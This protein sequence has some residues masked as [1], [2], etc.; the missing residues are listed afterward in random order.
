MEVDTDGPVAAMPQGPAA[1]Q[2]ATQEQSELSSAADRTST[3]KV[4]QTSAAESSV[5]DQA[6]QAFQT[7]AVAGLASG[8]AVHEHMTVEAERPAL[9]ASGPEAETKTEAGASLL[10]YNQPARSYLPW[11]NDGEKLVLTQLLHAQWELEKLKEDK[12][13]LSGSRLF[14][15]MS[16]KLAEE[17]FYRS[18]A[19]IE[20]RW[21]TFLRPREEFSGK[22]NFSST[23]NSALSTSTQNASQDP[24]I[25]ENLSYLSDDEH[26]E[27]NAM[28][29]GGTHWTTE[30][31]NILKD[32]VAQY[33]LKTNGTERGVT[34]L[35]QL[36]LHL[37]KKKNFER[38]AE[39]CRYV[40][41][42][43]LCTLP[44]ELSSRGTSTRQCENSAS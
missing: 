13:R 26:E 6:K 3:N 44:K 41:N 14:S 5:A 40:K 8:S 24:R 35:S 22:F 12:D 33:R 42:F 9:P 17:G 32:A 29:D 31:M 11:A 7:A 2:V 18:A 23:S 16:R 10:D 36:V 4:K 15:L 19:S 43:W 27:D 25:Q 37:L 21:Y 30:E 20:Y 34:E 28:V 39:A 38:S 1:M